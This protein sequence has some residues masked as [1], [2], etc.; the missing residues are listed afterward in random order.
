MDN[1]LNK[2]I[3]TE[4]KSRTYLNLPGNPTHS[5][6]Q[7]LSHLED[8]NYDHEYDFYSQ[9]MIDMFFEAAADIKGM[10]RTVSYDVQMINNIITMLTHPYV[11]AWLKLTDDVGWGGDFMK[12]L[13]N[14]QNAMNDL[15]DALDNDKLAHKKA[16]EVQKSLLKISNTMHKVS[17]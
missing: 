5:V 16:K 1:I 12:L 9:N 8:R 14:A 6:K 3:I 4:A 15:A 7:A 17:V 13:G 11:I 10:M 2:Y